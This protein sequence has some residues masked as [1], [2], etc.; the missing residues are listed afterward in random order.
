MTYRIHRS[1]EPDAVVFLLSGELDTEH[2]NRLRE[3]VDSE[4]TARV[5]LDLREVTVVYRS[6]LSFLARA[7]AD[8]IKIVNCADYIRRL[9]AA[10]EPR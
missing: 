10:E 4:T 9:I 6:G 7:E 3:L 1:V 2:V 8:G 5:R